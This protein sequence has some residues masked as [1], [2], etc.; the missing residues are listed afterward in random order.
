MMEVFAIILFFLL[1]RGVQGKAPSP[2]SSLS[3]V[4]D[5]IIFRNRGF[6]VNQATFLHVRIPLYLNDIITQGEVFRQ[7]AKTLKQQMQGEPDDTLSEMEGSFN[8]SIFGEGFQDLK[9]YKEASFA[10]GFLMADFLLRAIEESYSKL[11]G[12]ISILPTRSSLNDRTLNHNVQ[13]RS[14]ASLDLQRTLLEEE[15]QM[16]QRAH[17]RQESTRILRRHKRLIL[18]GIA[19]DAAL[20]ANYKVDELA[21]HFNQFLT[22]KYAGLVDATE[23]LGKDFLRLKVDSRL[24]VKLQLIFLSH[25]PLKFMAGSFFINQRIL[26]NYQRILNAV[27]AAQYQR[28][29]PDILSGE[30]LH[31]LFKL[32]IAHAKTHSCNLYV[33]KPSDLFQV[34]LSHLYNNVTKTLNLFLHVPMVKNNNHLVLKEYIPFPLWQSFNLNASVT[35]TLGDI[36]YIAVTNDGVQDPKVRGRFR[37][38]TE[39]ELS[40]CKTLGELYLCPGRNTVRKVASDT[41]IGSLLQRDPQKIVDSCEMKVSRPGEHVARMGYNK[42]LVSTPRPFS[43]NAK[44]AGSTSS[45]PLWVGPQSELTL[46]EDCEIELADYVLSTDLNVNIDF[47]VKAYPCGALPSLFTNFI[48]NTTLLRSVI[49]EALIE[50]ESLTSGDLQHLKQTEIALKN[51]SVFG[52]LF[53]FSGLFSFFQIFAGVGASALGLM[54]IG[55]LILCCCRQEFCSCAMGSIT[56]CFKCGKGVISRAASIAS[57]A[58]QAPSLK[59]SPKEPF[60]ETPRVVFA[61]DV[62]P[63]MDNPPP[64]NPF[65]AFPRQNL[66][67]F[68]RGALRPARSLISI[69]SG[70]RTPASLRSLDNIFEPRPNTLIH[71]A[72]PAVSESISDSELPCKIGPMIQKGQRPSNFVCTHHLPETGC[73]GNM[74]ETEC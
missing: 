54:T 38:F 34:E 4:G 50:R 52:N 31:A 61:P 28:L 47:E 5:Q 16:L 67:R 71:E 43:A 51:Y 35:P 66:N 37:T 15:R 26:G 48:P 45:E 33:D 19:L 30:D 27:T 18:A 39:A 64:Y 69:A 17:H 2:P 10:D 9:K 56:Q 1:A 73:I 74:C 68:V 49:Q 22:K 23:T 32:V 46:P 6:V 63:E 3:V 44:C 21:S 58:S 55:I 8:F 40:A 42:W 41:C 59:E 62:P 57:I 7:D 14:L 53:D 36:K 29:S 60:P 13:K 20:N 70:F 24:L 12:I 65:Y 25:Q 11:L 72:G